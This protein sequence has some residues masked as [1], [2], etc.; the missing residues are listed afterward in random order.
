MRTHLLELYF[1]RHLSLISIEPCNLKWCTDHLRAMDAAER[2]HST[3]EPLFS[4]IRHCNSK[5]LDLL[6]SSTVM[7]SRLYTISSMREQWWTL[8]LFCASSCFFCLLATYIPSQ[9]PHKQRTEYHRASLETVIAPVTMLFRIVRQKT[10]QPLRIHITTLSWRWGSHLILI[11]Q[12]VTVLR[13]LVS[14]QQ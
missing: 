14:G 8:S 1:I 11:L 9:L 6:A 13:N 2:K 12:L 3:Q 10:L 7:W 5:W 4:S